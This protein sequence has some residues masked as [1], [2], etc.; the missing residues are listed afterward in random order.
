MSIKQYSSPTNP[1]V[2][3]DIEVDGKSKGRIV[4]E[5][6]KNI[7]PKTA[8]N[9]RQ[10][11][12]G[13]G[14]KSSRS[15][16]NPHYKGSV[17]HRVIKQFMMQGGDFTNFNGTGGESIYGLKFDDENFR[18]K[19]TEKGLLSSANAG[20]NT[21]GS[22]FFVTFAATPWLDGKHVVFGRVEK[23]YE[24]CQE[25]E[26]MPCNKEDKPHS[27]ITIA[28]CGEIKLEPVKKPEEPVKKE[29]EEIKTEEIK[30]EQVQENKKSR[31]RSASSE[32]I[33]RRKLSSSSGSGSSQDE[34][35]KK[36]DNHQKDRKSKKISKHHRKDKHSN[37]RR[38]RDRS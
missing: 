11:C 20:K 31:S 19:H 38:S 32:S 30:K 2:Y 27:R 22:Q 16:K 33:K 35:R 13:E 15:G 12:T 7:T 9:F 29:G 3:F 14:G 4:M 6:F 24:I 23:G 8:E 36:H 21:N 17:F 25:I 10:L 1:R 18:I 26:R 5:L 28:N 34:R 37:K